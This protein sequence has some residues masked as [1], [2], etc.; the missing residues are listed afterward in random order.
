MGKLSV[1]DDYGGNSGRLDVDEVIKHG[2]SKEA[3]TP[4]E[5]KDEVVLKTGVSERVY[6]RHLKRLLEIGEV[7]ET[8]EKGNRGRMV[9]K[10]VLRKKDSLLVKQVRRAP[11]LEVEP[12]RRLL[13]LAAWIKREPNGWVES[14]DVQKAR[15]LLTHYL[16][17]EIK[18]PLEDP[19]AYAFQWSDEKLERLDL[20]EL[21][22]LG[23]CN[24]ASSRFFDLRSVV[25]AVATGSDEKVLA[26]E[27]VFVGVCSAPMVVDYVGV[28]GAG[29][30]PLRYVGH[31]IGYAP[32][33]EL[34]SVCVAVRGGSAERI[35]VVGVE[36]R[37]GKPEKSWVKGL[38]KQLGAKKSRVVEFES[39][40][41]DVKRELLLKLRHV[42]NQ[43]GLVIPNRYA[44][45]VG[46]LWDYSYKS[47]SISYVLALATAVDLCLK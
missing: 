40:R 14:D 15:M 22:R 16:I 7:E 20:E 26:D 30:Q 32:V 1:T 43:R 10:Y 2:L 17:P 21:R 28:Y 13:E 9:R 8:F 46:E 33:E 37:S 3:K 19:D 39:L 45:L 27:P 47:P 36:T 44:S 6:F 29:M 4:K 38:A 11:V 34:G 31:P 23:F 42:L 24:F 12:T 5:L 35:R 41:E 25:D 18:A